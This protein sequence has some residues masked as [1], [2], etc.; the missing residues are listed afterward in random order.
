MAESLLVGRNFADL[1]T[2]LV[3]LVFSKKYVLGF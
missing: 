3:H 2:Y 1:L